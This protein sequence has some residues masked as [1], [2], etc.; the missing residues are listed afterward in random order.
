MRWLG[1]CLIFF[2]PLEA[3]SGRSEPENVV[4]QESQAQ[5]GK[6]ADLQQQN[7]QEA[8]AVA[9]LSFTESELEMMLPG[10]IENLQGFEKM[11]ERKLA[12]SVLPAYRYSPILPGISVRQSEMTGA[13]IELP[14]EVERP[15]DLAE[16]A[17]ADIPTLAALIKSRQV[18]C[19]EL[20]E[21][22]IARLRALDPTLKCVVTLTEERALVTAKGLD[23]ELAEGKWRGPLHGI[24]YGAKDLFAAA[25][26]KTTWGAK[27]YQSQ[28]FEF[29]ATVITQLESA[30]AV[31][32]AKLTLGA[33]AMGDVWFGGTTKNPWDLEQGSSGSSAGSASA[34]A[35]GCVPFALGTETLG[36]IV[37]P[38]RRC[39]V[40]AIRPTFGRI[41]RHGAMALSWTMDK[42]GPMARTIHDASLVLEV[43]A[44]LDRNDPT[45]VD[46]PCPAPGV[47]DPKG[48]KVG[49]PK[50]AFGGLRSSEKERP[51]IFAELTALGI[52]LVEIELP[53]FPIWPMMVILHAEAAAA[54]DELTRS[55]RDDELTRQTP[56]AWPNF[57]RVARLIPAVEYI[58]AN[59]LRTLLS[60][61]MA[62]VMESVDAIATPAAHGTI[63]GIT[64]LTGHPSVVAPCGFRENG[65]PYSIQFVGHLYDESRLAALA[66]AWQ[67]STEFHLRHP[68]L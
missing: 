9:G 33:L 65:R 5:Q 26:A 16:L 59:R 18:T 27:P 31:L 55:N 24:P 4:Q 41:S 13:P 47:F 58:R 21:L 11:R 40:S 10:V 68:G 30:G 35:A 54:F 57:F 48:M 32:V 14:K 62:R 28:Q 39:G 15:S 23:A 22:S 67:Q 6:S 19:V 66:R 36:S 20:A 64:N 56:D 1:V 61:E 37:S 49:V 17:Y 53:E 8:A 38:S 45:T 25:G 51:E 60:Q 42:V 34:V 50:G 52:E 44:G 2:S 12:N 63:L 7:L 46:L 3:G 29:D 43:L